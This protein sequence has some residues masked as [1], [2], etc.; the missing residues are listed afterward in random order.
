MTSKGR[1]KSTGQKTSRSGP[2]VARSVKAT[3]SG[4]SDEDLV[5]KV[6]DWTGESP[7]GEERPTSKKQV[8]SS[9]TAKTNSRTPNK[10]KSSQAPKTRPPSGRYTPPIPRSVKRSPAWYPFVLLGLLF[11]GVFII[12]VNYVSVLPGSPSNWY[13]IVAI[14]GILIAAF[15]ATTYR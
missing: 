14:V 2:S 7:Q 6:D 15:M 8:R 12:I 11:A 3:A 5:D 10:N 4:Q 13:T 9:A 1:S